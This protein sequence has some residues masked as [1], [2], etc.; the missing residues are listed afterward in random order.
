MKT[1]IHLHESYRLPKWQQWMDDLPRK[2][3]ALPASQVIQTGRNRVHWIEHEG[4][5]LVV[6]HFLNTGVW[7]KTVY[8]IWSGKA[9]RSFDHSLA[10]IQAGLRTPQPVA[11]REDWKGPFLKES[12]YVSGHVEIAQS[13]RAIRRLKIDWR[14]QVTKIAQSI[15][16]M[17]DA[18]L[19]HRDLTAGNFL[20]VGEKEEQWS[21]Y[22]I[23]NNRMSFG[24]IDLR[25]GIKSLLQP[26]IEGE[27]LEPY[28]AA[29]AQARE[30]DPAV[31]LKLYEGLMGG[32][33]LKWK[34]KNLTR[35]WRRKIGL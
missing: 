18:G 23:D 28:V 24:E 4:Q 17:H 26:K 30:F 22:I 29:Y 25:K 21:L 9:R 11:W 6:K 15:A 33:K 19:L 35:P 7:K 13:A 34:I 1:T 12:F 2:V 27:Y 10:L 32:H 14:P 20:F 8:R 31:C 3:A 5:K 16:R